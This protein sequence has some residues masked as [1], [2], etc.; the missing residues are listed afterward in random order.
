[1]H[2][3]Q[4]TLNPG[5]V[6]MGRYV[7]IDV[8]GKG[9]FSAVYLIQDRKR[10]DNFFALKEVTAFDKQAR[11]FFALEC[12]L[13]QRLD[14]PALP[15]VYN[16]F[17]DEAHDRMYMIMDYVEGP[18]LETLLRIQP[19]QRFSLPDAT[20]VLAPVVD[21]LEYLHQHDPPI[22]H[23]DLK[24]ANIIVP[25]V[26]GKTILVDFGIAKEYD[27]HGTTNAIRHC[28]PGYGAPEHYAGGTNVRTDIYGLGATLFTLLTGDIPPDAI[29]RLTQIGNDRGD[30][31]KPLSALVP[32]VPEHISKAIQRAMSLNMMQRY[33]SVKEFWQ[34]LQTEPGQKHISEALGS[35][36]GSPGGPEVPEKKGKVSSKSLH[37]LQ[38]P[39]TPEIPEQTIKV[40]QLLQGKEQQD[41]GRSRNRVLLPIFLTLLFLVVVGA[42]FLGFTFIHNQITSASSPK[43]V[44][45]IIVNPAESLAA[46]VTITHV[47]TLARTYIGTIYTSEG[48][49]Y[50]M[51][52]TNVHQS[53][54]YISGTFTSSLSSGDFNGFLD[55]S[56]HIY[57]TVTSGQPL[58][59]TGTVQADH[60]IS[61]DN[62]CS[63][64][65]SNNCIPGQAT[66]NWS[67][68][69][70]R[71]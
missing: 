52:L 12:S 46:T 27:S 3:L 54:G 45:A 50:Q 26:G 47:A 60:S 8:L 9:G 53:G 32:S 2:E 66:G 34:T 17:A 51:S 33:S 57:F 14:H 15:R 1:M 25:V 41:G 68:A 18:N 56:G 23:R 62:F 30:P 63:I 44:S 28:T 24:P 11:D 31:L 5:T 20:A 7:V 16:A 65:Q 19:K 70:G 37:K 22:I 71:P 69:P 35:I 58:Y 36:V 61:G 6:I 38:L 10:E 67:A 29:D 64:D 40:S 55:N 21:A 42:S 39:T 4:V 48:A 49:P 13:L 59:F 43:V